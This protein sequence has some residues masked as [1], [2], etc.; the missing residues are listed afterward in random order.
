[1]LINA[2]V[3][4]FCTRTLVSAGSI[5]S[6]L[7]IL[8]FIPACGSGGSD[9]GG[10]NSI[11]P[12]AKR[13]PQSIFLIGNDRSSINGESEL[14]Q[15]KDDGTGFTLIAAIDSSSQMRDMKFADNGT[16]VAFKLKERVGTHFELYSW[17]IAANELVK[18]GSTVSDYDWSPDGEHLVFSSPKKFLSGGYTT[19]D[20][21]YRVTRQG[22]NESII[23]GSVGV[24]PM[25]EVVK[26]TWSPD[27][28]Y[29]IQEVA[30]P[31][32]GTGTAFALNSHE[33]EKGGTNSRRLLQNFQIS[34]YSVSENS[35]Y[36]VV[37]S[38]N[39]NFAIEVHTIEL[40]LPRQAIRLISREANQYQVQHQFSPDEKYLAYTGSDHSSTL[41]LLELDAN[42]YITLVNFGPQNDTQ[43]VIRQIAWSQDSKYL[44]FI[45]KQA[46]ESKHSLY[47]IEPTGNLQKLSAGVEQHDSV[48]SFEWSPNSRSIAYQASSGRGG[49]DSTRVFDLYSVE[50]Q[51]GEVSKLTTNLANYQTVVDYQWA[52]NSSGITYSSGTLVPTHTSAVAENLF[53]ANLQS[54]SI[55][56]INTDDLEQINS[57]GYVPQ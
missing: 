2:S 50:L 43:I 37:S 1:M 8:L 13:T 45:G 25:V 20:Q 27:G 48:V 42:G 36:L 18:A 17:S 16:A 46:D 12:P 3:L 51:L 5:A 11:P 30:S 21:I 6:V 9:G 23:N 39:S 41:E 35:K 14:Y 19:V 47:V 55:D 28:R 4:K 15:V 34:D 40:S 38:L 49:Q 10:T 33:I 29:I 56:T 52:P 53:Y 57:F 26:P 44:A 24:P 31:S 32:T 54:K 22:D 7:V